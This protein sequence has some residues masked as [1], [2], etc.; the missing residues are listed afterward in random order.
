LQD[1]VTGK[2]RR[3]CWD[4][5][6]EYADRRRLDGTVAKAADRA[7]DGGRGLPSALVIANAAQARGGLKL[8]ALADAGKPLLPTKMSVATRSYPLTRRA[9]AFVDRKPGQR[10]APHIEGFL[11]FIL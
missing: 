10:L 5:I 4:R 9:Y 6:S 8:V 1:R 7:G 3:M 2:D 11:R